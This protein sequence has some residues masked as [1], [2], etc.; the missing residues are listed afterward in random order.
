MAND[1]R[2]FFIWTA[3]VLIFPS[4]MIAYKLFISNFEGSHARTPSK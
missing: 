4:N 2:H 3:T 1:T